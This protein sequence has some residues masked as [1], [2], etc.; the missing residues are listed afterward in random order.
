MSNLKLMKIILEKNKK[1]SYNDLLSEVLKYPIGKVRE[2]RN[3][4]TVLSSS[5]ISE[6]SD[7]KELLLYIEK[8]SR[9]LDYSSAKVYEEQKRKELKKEIRLEKKER[10]EATKVLVSAMESQG[11][12]GNKNRTECFG[13]GIV[14][15][16]NGK[17]KC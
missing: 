11:L 14:V 16:A 10:A 4:N 15:T 5:N 17:C 3:I 1:I 13:C 6:F 9:H 12:V 7:A 2:L 8:L